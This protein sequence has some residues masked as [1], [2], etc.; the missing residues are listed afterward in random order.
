MK[1]YHIF[2]ICTKNYR[3]AYEFSI[4][5]WLSKAVEKVYVYTDDATWQSDN[6][7]VEII[8][9]FVESASWLINVGRKPAA[10]L[11]LLSTQPSLT[12]IIFLDADCFVRHELG[13]MFEKKFDFAPTLIEH[14]DC[15]SS[16]VWFFRN[17]ATVVAM[18]ERWKKVQ[19]K[20]KKA[21]RG[22]SPHRTS[23]SQLALDTI[24][25]EHMAG[26]PAKIYLES[27]R[28]YNRGISTQDTDWWS[29][30]GI[31]L[32]LRGDLERDKVAILHFQGNEYRR[33]KL[34]A[35]VAEAW[36]DTWQG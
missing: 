15:I 13:G 22:M 7:R 25:R 34:L 10:A 21:G 27:S 14:A 16:G 24:V 4:A 8:P 29:P 31:R 33:P 5:S 17:N 12:N 30:R 9:H 19:R 1:P 36:G 6:E 23:Y 28:F 26:G 35:A 32:P 20:N 18:M 2:T 11:H 3:D